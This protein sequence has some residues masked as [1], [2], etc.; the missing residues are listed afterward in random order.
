[1][2]AED[3][4]CPPAGPITQ[5]GLSLNVDVGLQYLSAWLGGN[6][7]VP[8]YNLMEDAATAEICRAQVWQWLRHG[9]TLDDGRTITAAVVGG[10]IDEHVEKLSTSIAPAQLFTA[11]RLF[12]ELVTAVD[13]PEFLTS[14][15]YDHLE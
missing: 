12:E 3:L 2:A 8:I 7:C 9:A 6:G 11:A 1:M 14:R 13:F 5:A 4:L 10:T 15:A